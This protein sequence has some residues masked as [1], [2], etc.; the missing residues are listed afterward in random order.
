MRA[1]DLRIGNLV[2]YQ[3]NQNIFEVNEISNTG[4][5]VQDDIEETWIELEYFEPIPLTE[6]WLLRFGFEKKFWLTKGIVIKCVYYQLGDIVVYLLKDSFEIELIKQS[7]QFN[8]FINFKKEVH[9][10]QNLYF[11]LTNQELHYKII[12]N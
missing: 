8:L 9:I 7:G 6:E 12:K 1:S 4:L 11:A 3:D 5:G 10:L 2:K